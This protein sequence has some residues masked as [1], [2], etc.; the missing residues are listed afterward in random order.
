MIANDSIDRQTARE[1][2]NEWKATMPVNSAVKMNHHTDKG[3]QL[4]SHGSSNTTL[5]IIL[6]EWLDLKKF[7]H[8]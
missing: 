3:V 8:H 4:Q 1:D 5:K 2:D 7:I 6:K